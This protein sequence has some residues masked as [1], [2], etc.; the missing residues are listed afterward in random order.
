MEQ[1]QRQSMFLCTERRHYHKYLG[2]L[3][4]VNPT[5]IILLYY[6]YIAVKLKG[7]VYVVAT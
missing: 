7:K 3:T 1:S 6:K 4:C 2:S 5:A